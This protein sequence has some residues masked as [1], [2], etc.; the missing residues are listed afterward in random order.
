MDSNEG[1]DDCCAHS[2]GS[3]V[4]SLSSSTGTLRRD[5][6][7]SAEIAQ[8]SEHI[9]SLLPVGSRDLLLPSDAILMEAVGVYE[10][11]RRF[12]VPLQLAPF[13]FE[14]FCA[15]TAS[16]MVSP[17]L[18]EMHISLLR[19][20]HK[21]NEEKGV[22]FT[23]ND[24]KSSYDVMFVLALDHLTWPS[25]LLQFGEGNDW[26]PRVMVI[27][28]GD[29]PYCEYVS[30]LAI[31][32]W[33][34][35]LA[36]QSNR[37][38]RVFSFADQGFARSSLQAGE[39][40]GQPEEHCRACSKRNNLVHCARCGAAFHRYC[41]PHDGAA[42]WECVV[43]QSCHVK[44][45]TDVSQC[46]FTDEQE[47]IRLEVIGYD[48]G[49]NRYVF[50]GHRLL[51][52]GFGRA[53][54]VLYYS[55]Y[56]KVLEVERALSTCR[57]KSDCHDQL[58]RRL[59]SAGE[60]MRG[61]MEITL[62]LTV[63]R[64][65][66]SNAAPSWL[67]LNAGAVDLARRT[68]D[69]PA[70]LP[71]VDGCCSDSSDSASFETADE[72]A[73]PVAVEWSSA[74]QS[75]DSPTLDM[76]A[77]DFSPDSVEE[78]ALCP[79]QLLPR[80]STGG[81]SGFLPRKDNAG[82][83]DV[84]DG[85]EVTAK[86]WRKPVLSSERRTRT[87]T[88]TIKPLAYDLLEKGKL[89]CPPVTGQPREE[90]VGA[91]IKRGP[92]EFT[93]TIPHRKFTR[94]GR[95]FRSPP[96]GE[97]NE[98][99]RRYTSRTDRRPA[100]R[101]RFAPRKS[102]CS[103]T[104]RAAN[105]LAVQCA[106]R[107]VSARGEEVPKGHATDGDQG[108]CL[109][110]CTYPSMFG[111]D[112]VAD[113]L[114]YKKTLG[115]DVIRLFRF[116]GLGSSKELVELLRHNRHEVALIAQKMLSSITPS[117]Y[118]R[119]GNDHSYLRY[120]NHYVMHEYSQSKVNYVY[121]REKKNQMTRKYYADASIDWSLSELVESSPSREDL[122]LG[123]CALS[124]GVGDRSHLLRLVCIVMIVLECQMSP[125]SM[126]R[127]WHYRRPSWAAAV[128]DCSVATDLAELLLELEGAI[129]PMMF[130]PSYVNSL[131]SVVWQRESSA[132][133][134]EHKR[135]EA[136]QRRQIDSDMATHSQVG[137]GGGK[138]IRSVMSKVRSEEYRL[139]GGGWCWQRSLCTGKAMCNTSKIAQ[140]SASEESA[141]SAGCGVNSIDDEKRFID[142]GLKHVGNGH[143]IY[144]FLLDGLLEQRETMQTAL[145]AQL[146][147]SLKSLQIRIQQDT[148]RP[149]CTPTFNTWADALILTQGRM[150]EALTSDNSVIE[151][152]V[153]AGEILNDGHVLVVYKNETF[154]LPMCANDPSL[155]FKLGGRPRSE[156][157]KT[158]NPT[159]TC[160][161]S[162]TMVSLY[163][164]PNSVRYAL[165]RKGSKG[166]VSGFKGSRH[167]MWLF[168]FC[169]PVQQVVWRWRTRS[170]THL[171]QV[172]L[173]LKLLW[174]SLR[175]GSLEKTSTSKPICQE[176]WTDM[177]ITIHD[178]RD[179][180]SDRLCSEYL[181]EHKSPDGS[182]TI[183][184]WLSEHQLPIA[185]I[186]EF[187]VAL[188]TYRL[189]NRISDVQTNRT[190]PCADASDHCSVT[191]SKNG[192]HMDGNDVQ[193]SGP[194]EF[195]SHEETLRTMRMVS[196]IGDMCSNAGQMSK[197]QATCTVDDCL[198]PALSYNVLRL[199]GKKG[200][201]KSDEMGSTR[202]LE[203]CSMR[204]EQDVSD[205][206]FIYRSFN[207]QHS[208]GISTPA[209]S[210][211]DKRRR[212]KRSN[213]IVINQP[214]VAK[215]LSNKIKTAPAVFVQS[216]CKSDLRKAEVPSINPQSIEFE[217]LS[218]PPEPSPVI[219]AFKINNGADI[220]SFVGNDPESVKKQYMQSQMVGQMNANLPL[221]IQQ[222]TH[223]RGVKTEISSLPMPFKNSLKLYGGSMFLKETIGMSELTKTTVAESVSKENVFIPNCTKL[224][225]E[226]TSGPAQM[227]NRQL[228]EGIGRQHSSDDPK[229]RLP[230]Y[231]PSNRSIRTA[232]QPKPISTLRSIASICTKSD[233]ARA[234]VFRILPE[235]ARDLYKPTRKQLR[236]VEDRK[237]QIIC[238][239]STRSLQNGVK[240]MCTENSNRSHTGRLGS[241]DEK[242]S[243]GRRKALK[244]KD[245]R[246]KVDS[247]VDT[248]F[249][250]V[251]KFEDE[252]DHVQGDGGLG[253]LEAHP[254]PLDGV[255][256]GQ[257]D[258]VKR[259]HTIGSDD[260][261]DSRL[262]AEQHPP[263][264]RRCCRYGDRS[265]VSLT[266]KIGDC[267]RGPTIR[268]DPLT[269]SS[270]PDSKC[271]NVHFAVG[272]ILRDIE[273]AQSMPSDDDRSGQKLYCIC[274]TPYDKSQFYIGCD[275][276]HEWFHGSCVN[277]TP[278]QADKMDLY[279]CA[280]CYE[281]PRCVMDASLSHNMLK[282]YLT[283]LVDEL[284]R[285]ESSW[286]FREPVD[287]TK[288]PHYYQVIKFPMDLATV[289]RKIEERQYG[290]LSNFATDIMRIFDNS[291]QF[292]MI[293]SVYWECADELESKFAQ[294]LHKLK[295]SIRKG[296]RVKA[297]E[298]EHFDPTVLNYTDEIGTIC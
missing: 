281:N 71:Q 222:A 219:A 157:S 61:Q 252:M 255:M 154:K 123:K 127:E 177:A 209:S 133:R 81:Q 236:M 235:L 65:L 191:T 267:S 295:K 234:E 231:P 111:R 176:V 46:V 225:I 118:Y 261:S 192:C 109:A 241:K 298:T 38:H 44:G 25:V 257:H 212:S 271:A 169:K 227:L 10:M 194:C 151:E 103:K 26:P 250:S 47:C 3:R 199:K 43:C 68:H 62:E 54:V 268:L 244:R 28:C 84:C 238:E 37:A 258:G 196:S 172:A 142:E 117:E 197:T 140:S 41:V 253:E 87:T 272:K 139:L 96:E 59:Q 74:R 291:R 237:G 93:I 211:A 190:N 17:L 217:C 175:Q 198:H 249:E 6:S 64:R 4:P 156:F 112:K 12:A 77:I 158:Q 138:R 174:Y 75:L 95:P 185:T 129:K 39:P 14:D 285:F 155:P 40:H 293:G 128:A 58:V 239:I 248:F 233:A 195:S 110:K 135:E 108:C 137:S 147:A 208:S 286:P 82:V 246:E 146:G 273:N 206:T 200:D 107:G 215:N 124:A 119:L 56:D 78:Q 170:A 132:M 168:P 49:L 51:V 53:D 20:L 162:G 216:Q 270:C 275:S 165:A 167:P 52:E 152:L 27:L 122:I 94:Y 11:L 213:V 184:H 80:A 256:G 276:C 35:E 292:N 207:D 263:K 66:A 279:Y 113:S 274:R 159:R 171:S 97:E 288:Y 153:N 34:C 9:I 88:G 104:M 262:F 126:H 226:P 243:R 45:V 254:D 161:S 284:D 245:I 67:E 180:G 91:S 163:D 265:S 2:A 105:A 21:D 1:S 278:E 181:I 186:H 189:S 182:D 297:I 210:V 296:L 22:T 106:E 144:P 148:G 287:A 166:T 230:G 30:R 63:E 289:R 24:L 114:T 150:Y 164:I 42:T 203:T 205:G 247:L 134:E 7:S 85:Q 218:E 178:R 8:L 120:V 92:S 60:T 32:Q 202:P 13:R 193:R 23:H 90:Y 277:V 125:F 76:T 269:V 19:L 260:S 86:A 69:N 99:R 57:Q 264:R 283:K 228:L 266:G 48:A 70:K 121:N 201:A 98:G 214:R 5:A 33:M 220:A 79:E 224:N 223:Q 179:V 116:L 115:K 29:Y 232:P 143:P 145:Q 83:T 55:S 101:R 229:Y 141:T 130:H 251:S 282:L 149:A 221:R 36:L 73:T 100:R 183:K 18:C 240:L 16:P 188:E 31:L 15:A 204:W 280:R 89:T 259:G 72:C 131:S 160:H 50:A 173:Q 136:C 242:A 294:L 187:N 102:A 290:T